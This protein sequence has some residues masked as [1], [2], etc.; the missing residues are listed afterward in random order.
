MRIGEVWRLTSGDDPVADIVIND[1]DFPWLYGRLVPL[2]AFDRFRPLFDQEL[3][4]VESPDVAAW[5]SVHAKI[6]ASLT[7]H[8]PTG[9]VAEYLLHVDGDEAWFRWVD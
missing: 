3:A 6:A 1:S 5:D 9:P 2:P 7:L 8:A 4:L